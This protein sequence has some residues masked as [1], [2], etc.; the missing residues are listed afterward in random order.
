M[1]I[2]QQLHQKALNVL[3]SGG[4]VVFPTDTVYGLLVDATNESAVKKL[5]AFKERPKGKPISVF[6]PG[7][8][9]IREVV[10]L[11]TSD[12]S[13]IKELLPGPY[14]VIFP[15]NHTV[16]RLLESE[17]GTLGIRLPQYKAVNDL[18]KEFGKPVTATSANRSGR[19][20]VHSI[21]ALMNQLSEKQKSMINLVVDIG[22][23]PA[24]KPSTV[25]DM[26]S[27]DVKILRAGDMPFS[28]SK[29][30]VS[31][32]ENET[33]QIA[34]GIFKDVSHE[35]GMTEKPIV[36]ILQGDLGAGKTQFVKGIGESLRIEERIVSPT[37]VILNEYVVR[38]GAYKHLVHMDLYNIKDAEE[39]KHL[40]IEAY[41]NAPN[42]FCIEWGEKS[43]DVIDILK[44]KARLI[45][46]HIKHVD[47]TRREM[48][49][50]Y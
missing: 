2:A 1:E 35:P 10:S 39:F 11:D 44:E 48:T 38:E 37:Y 9:S 7:F 25:V 19:P 45:Y 23:L 8:E 12:V 29:T 40:G 30:Y 27:D 41:L 4:I 46:I 5:I 16:S 14:T 33:K 50:Q 6:V 28:L 43:A 24:N 34:Q 22:S 36:F 31:N 13:R 21:S 15:S 47:E 32:S 49:V 3:K 17:N 26:T 20:S 42:V 18:V